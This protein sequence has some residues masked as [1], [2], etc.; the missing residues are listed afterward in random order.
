MKTALKVSLIVTSLAI[1]AGGAYVAFTQQQVMPQTQF[2]TV[3]GELISSADLKGKVTL[4]NFWATSCAPCI[5][6]MPKF[7]Q[8]YNEFKGR[9][10]ETILVAMDY[11]PPAYVKNFSERNK[12]P[13]KVAMDARGEI[14]KSF[15]DV[16]I[17]PTT[18][19]IDK[20][21]R[22]IKS[23]LGE[24]DFGKLHELIDTALKEST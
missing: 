1:A 6:E 16:S 19:L 2:A 17:T 7:T 5:S 22:I 15:G 4:V 20:K 14:A 13:F 24:P 10:L 3:N 11:D 12:L 21:G 18:F 23:Y 9:G 8:T